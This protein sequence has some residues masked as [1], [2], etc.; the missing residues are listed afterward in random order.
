MYDSLLITNLINDKL[1]LADVVGKIS[2]PE[3]KASRD[4]LIK[5]ISNLNLVIGNENEFQSILR[6]I[7]E[8]LSKTQQ[9]LSKQKEFNGRMMLRLTDYKQEIIKLNDLIRIKDEQAKVF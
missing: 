9:E 2:K 5:V 3:Q 4:R 7:S 8:E 1:Y 6:M